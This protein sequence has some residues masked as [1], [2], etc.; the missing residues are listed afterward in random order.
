MDDASTPEDSRRSRVGLIVAGS[1][2]LVRPWGVYVDVGLEHVGYI[3]PVN[4]R[5]AHYEAGDR[6]EAY[7]VDFRERSRVYELRPKGSA[8]PPDG[9]QQAVSER[10]GSMT[11]R[12]TTGCS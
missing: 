5:D 3:D 12:A 2:S 11:S 8:S 4:I 9:G 1:V 10:L 6:V 7:V